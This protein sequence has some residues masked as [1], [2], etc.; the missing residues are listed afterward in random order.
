MAYETQDPF[1]GGTK[2]PSLSWKDCPVGTVFTLEV[3]D[4]PKL[5]QSRDFDTGEPAF[6]D[7]TK[8]Q[9]KM[10]AVVNGRVLSGPHSV[11]EERSI[12]AQKPS[13]MFQA[14]AAA[15]AAAGQGI[16]IAPGGKLSLRFQGEKAHENKRFNPI[17]I[18]EARYEPPVGSPFVATPATPSPSVAAHPGASPVNP[19]MVGWGNAQG[20]L[21]SPP[22]K[23]TW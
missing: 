6:W 2:T 11:G 16:L 22:T 13:S 20:T 1:A 10:S 12:W 5:L 18:Y 19:G 8:Q 21:V 17:K 9:P 7:D 14:I 23:P 4:T 15:Q 3:L